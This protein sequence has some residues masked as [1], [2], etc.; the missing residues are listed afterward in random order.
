MMQKQHTGTVVVV[1]LTLSKEK[2][3]SKKLLR[4]KNMILIKQIQRMK[5]FFKLQYL[6]RANFDYL[7]TVYLC[8]M[9]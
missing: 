3:S 7:K 1:Q 4:L 8:L 5:Y 6:A 9:Q 2:C